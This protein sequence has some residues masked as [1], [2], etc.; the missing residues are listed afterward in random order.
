MYID[1]DLIH[2][3]VD[4]MSSD[5]DFKIQEYLSFGQNHEKF[6][7]YHSVWCS[8]LNGTEHSAISKLKHIV[9]SSTN[10]II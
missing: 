6:L 8:V 9:L 3:I 7:I 2:I 1:L 5:V 4:S 10:T